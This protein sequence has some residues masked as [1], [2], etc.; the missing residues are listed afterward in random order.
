MP[1]LNRAAILVT[2]LGLLATVSGCLADEDEA[3]FAIYSAKGLMTENCGE[4][5]LLAGPEQ[6]ALRIGIRLVGGTGL[7][8]DHGDGLIMGVIDD[9][10][11]FAMSR[12]MRIVVGEGNEDEPECLVERIMNISG[13]LVGNVDED[14]TFRNF[15]AIMTNEYKTYDGSDCAGLLEGDEKVADELPCNV[16][17]D[18]EGLRE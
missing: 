13:T 12:F 6:L 1:L 7:H 10:G 11:G 18:L 4:T 15:D 5:G 3:P 17:Y 2:G 16:N 14:G 8:W 9:R